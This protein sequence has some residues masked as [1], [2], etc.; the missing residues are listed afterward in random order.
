MGRAWLLAL[1]PGLPM[2]VAAGPEPALREVE[3][4]G[5]LGRDVH[6]ADGRDIGRIVD[7]VVEP[8]GKPIAVVVDAGGF[9]GVGSRRVAVDWA[10][11][12][13]PAPA[14]ADAPVSIDL[15][16]DQVRSAPAYNDRTK[17]AMVVGAPESVAPESAVP[18]SAGPDPEAGPPAE[19]P[20][21]A[22]DGKAPVP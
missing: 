3:A 20:P 1:M 11:V 9:M 13:V 12:H 14:A 2:L 6:D 19:G 18:D 21:A 22:N 5:V 16:D 4:T 17:P 15:T 10:A 7:V 8:S